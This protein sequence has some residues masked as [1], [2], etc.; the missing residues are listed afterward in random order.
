MRRIMVIRRRR[1]TYLGSDRTN[2]EIADYKLKWNSET[3]S[4]ACDLPPGSLAR[5]SGATSALGGFFWSNQ[6]E[7]ER[8]R[9]RERD[10]ALT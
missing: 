2:A 10:G 1:S 9:E 4:E 5:F 6:G 7:R 8:E 3:G